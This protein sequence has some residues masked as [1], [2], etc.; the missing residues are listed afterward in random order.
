MALSHAYPDDIID[1]LQ[2]DPDP[3]AERSVSLLRTPQL[4]LLRLVLPGGHRMP[5][6]RVTGEVTIQ[7]LQGRAVI[8]TPQGPRPLSTGQLVVLAANEPHD[9]SATENA[10]LLVTILHTTGH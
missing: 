5:E 10:Q 8:G 1:L 6:H 7:C 9:V 4:Q 2:A 3:S